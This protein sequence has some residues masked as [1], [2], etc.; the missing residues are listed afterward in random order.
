MNFYRIAL[1]F[2]GTYLSCNG[3][4][5]QNNK[6]VYSKAAELTMIGKILPGKNTY[7]RVDTADY[8]DLPPFVKTLL[9]RSAG[10]AVTFKTNSN[11]ISAKWC[12]TE[13]KVSANMTAIAYKGL[14]L[15]IKN[16]GK[17]QF[18]GVG[19]PKDNCG[20]GVI[21]KNLANG[22]KECLLYFP[23][24][25]QVINPQ[26]GIDSGSTIS[27]IANPFKKNIL[28]YG[29]S[30]LQGASASRPGLA[31]PARLSRETG[32]NFLNLGL[33]GSARME[34]AAAD[35]VASV[36]ADAYVLD[37]VPN[38]S[39]E[40]INE[41]TAY[42]VN[43]IRSKHPTAP[44][45]IIQ[46]IFRENSYFDQVANVRMKAQNDNMMKQFL[47]LKKSGVKDLYIITADN[48]LGNDHEGTTDGTH[49]NDLGFDR[50]LLKLKPE[51]TAIL[52]KYNIL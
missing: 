14:D 19:I 46:S 47:A 11:T 12:T 1:L 4:F 30:I 8:P 33:S 31:Y 41:R 32:L 16:N 52:K 43:T 36:Q 44:I 21:V 7:H 2:L 6:P 5:A 27:P 40:Q 29:S 26:I 38:S 45:I 22:E 39:P 18:A 50:M 17:W 20:D 23:L 9:T 15:Y 13:A 24:Y 37:C 25:D 51:I 28:I 49:P 34:K 10:M 48:L 42:L 35:L 3:L